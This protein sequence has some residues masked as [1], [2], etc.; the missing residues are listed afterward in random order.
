[1]TDNTRKAIEDYRARQTARANYMAARHRKEDAAT[2]ERLKQV[3]LSAIEVS[4]AS[5]KILTTDEAH[6][7]MRE[8]DK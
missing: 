2:I 8:V 3:E 7:F 4:K 6:E 5:Y 1:M